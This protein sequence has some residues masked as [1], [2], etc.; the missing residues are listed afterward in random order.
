M[1][2]QQ[3]AAI[4]LRWGTK[5]WFPQMGVIH[6]QST[7][8]VLS[9]VFLDPKLCLWAVEAIFCFGSINQPACSSRSLADPRVLDDERQKHGDA[10][11]ERGDAEA[12]C[13]LCCSCHFIDWTTALTLLRRAKYCCKKWT[14][15]HSETGN[16][17]RVSP[18][19]HQRI[20]M[21]LCLLRL[22]VLPSF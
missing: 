3:K 14:D 1:D 10:Q 11:E 4:P 15:R 17:T 9:F 2:R 21:A 13:S 8:C 16:I 19:Y 22:P 20:G 18:C 6:T 5:H 12:V 7:E